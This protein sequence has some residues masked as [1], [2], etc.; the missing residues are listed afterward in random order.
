MFIFL[1]GF[2]AIFITLQVAAQHPA[3]QPFFRVQRVQAGEGACV[4][5]GESGAYRLEIEFAIKTEIY[6][7]SLDA[8]TLNQLRAL[9]A[10]EQLRRLS[11]TD[12]HRPLVTD[13][14]DNLQLAI[15]RDREWQQLTFITPE[16]RA[17]F[18]ES[19]EPLLHWLA[20]V[21]KHRPAATRVEGSATRC[22]PPPP[23][24]TS[25]SAATSGPT[26]GADTGQNRFAFRL[27]ST[28]GYRSSFDSTCTVVYQDGRYHWE[29]STQEYRKDREDKVAEDQL[30]PSAMKELRSILGAADLQ[31]SPGNEEI[32]WHRPIGEGTFTYLSI[33]REQG[34]QNLVFV[35]TFNPLIAGDEGM[36]KTRN[37]VTDTKVIEPL[38]NW[39]KREIRPPRQGKETSAKADDCAIDA[40]PKS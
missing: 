39:M 17:P 38:K 11:Q 3:P 26:V 27:F 1:S 8:S 36:S 7:G 21:K 22:L 32:E 13:S 18:K 16:S 29:R 34:V 6:A 30:S 19:L 25:A 9:L 28:H 15:W 33:A 4:L 20:D 23:M 5:V 31:N 14:T 35:A 37:R 2:V 12:I 24:N 40:G 10:N